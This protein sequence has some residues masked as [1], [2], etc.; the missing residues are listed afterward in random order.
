VV[1]I[2]GSQREAWRKSIKMADA[3][4]WR[5]VALFPAESVPCDDINAIGMCLSG[6]RVE[7]QRKWGASWLALTLWQQ[8]EIADGTA[9][10]PARTCR[11]RHP[12]TQRHV[13][14][15]SAPGRGAETAQRNAARVALKG[16]VR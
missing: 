14:P 9:S 2:N 1:D 11:L 8:F 15:R 4:V 13:R 16:L 10:L 5:Q 7:R 12:R 3:G 6:P